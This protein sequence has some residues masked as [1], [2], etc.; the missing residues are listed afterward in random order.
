M[1]D[2]DAYLATLKKPEFTLNGKTYT[3]RIL[4]VE[5]WLPFA[6][7]F[8]KLG[9]DELS[10]TEILE[11]SR[12]FLRALYP[13]RMSYR[14]LGD[15]VTMLMNSPALEPVVADFFVLMVQAMKPKLRT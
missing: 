6:T 9:N 15:P 2:A 7:R 13:Y 8:E 10:P 4:S 5:Q 14:W 3:G 1:F 11:L 12:D